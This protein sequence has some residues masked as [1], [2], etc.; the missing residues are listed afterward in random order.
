METCHIY[1]DEELLEYCE[2]T[3]K[4]LINAE[5]E[6]L[7]GLIYYGNG[8]RCPQCKNKIVVIPF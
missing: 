6:E 5:L 3:N 7:K 4:P 2:H 8:D 1:F